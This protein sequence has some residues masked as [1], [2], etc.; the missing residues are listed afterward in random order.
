MQEISE[1]VHGLERFGWSLKVLIV[2]DGKDEEFHQLCAT[3]GSDYGVETLVVGGP[4]AGL[5]AAIL[6]GFGRCLADPE[7]ELII[8]LDADG[9]HDARQIGDL[10]RAHTTTGADI[11]IGS[12]WTRGGRC[13]GL[14]F[15]RKVLSR[16][17]AKFLHLAGVPSHVKDPTTSFRVYG[18][19]AAVAMRRELVGFNGFSFFGATIAV[20]AAHDLTVIET[21]IHF[22]PRL[23]GNSNLRFA[24]IKRA[25]RDLPSIRSMKKQVS[26]RQIGF[27]G[28]EHGDAGPDQYNARRELELLSN[29]PRSTEI[30]L[31]ELAPHLGHRVV[32]VGAG[33]GQIS[34]ML[35]TRGHSVTAI[36]P[37]P[38][39][40]AKAPDLPARDSSSR[41]CGTLG[42]YLDA[43]SNVV[44][45]FD[46]ALYVNVLEHIEN[47]VDEVKQAAR[48]LRSGGSLVIF[49]PALPALYG[50]MD[51]ISGHYRRYRKPELRSVIERAGLV[52]TDLHYF[53]PVGVLP[54]WLAYAVLRRKTLDAGSVKMYD[55]VIIPTSKV[56]SNITRRKI[57]GKNLIA[58]GRKP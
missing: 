41:F 16:T 22:R 15:S 39:L 42:D 4:E 48:A 23:S 5:G 12:R 19:S 47:D 54:Y 33:L 27:L 36:E 11:T 49:V 51:E 28:A 37:D 7:V 30:I 13:Y 43:T 2:D 17:S 55:K 31:D 24:Q 20:A 53:D 26:R 9:Q 25:V 32:E 8:N 6:D 1:S 50:T 57:V 44:S 29:T 14:T 34:G 45:T 58:V 3:L 10:L 56:L 46:T 52:V 21:P 18:R 38:T 40:F 35:T